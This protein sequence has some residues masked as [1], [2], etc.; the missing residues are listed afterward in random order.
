LIALVL[1]S[2]PAWA[3]P[4]S[5]LRGYGAQ[6]PSIVGQ[7]VDARTGAPLEKVLVLVEDTGNSALTDAD[8][9]FRIDGLSAGPHRLYVSVVGYALYRREV[10]AGPDA[11][12]VTVRLSEGTTAY[13]ETLTV[14]PEVFRAPADPVPSSQVLGSAELL[15]LRGVLADDPLRAVQVLPGVATGDDLRSE[16]TVRGSDFRHLTFTVDGFATPYL[17][18]SVRGVEDRGPTGSVAMINSDV[19]ED[20]TLLNGS[21]PQRYAG[22]TGAEV[23]FR[24]RDGSRDRRIFHAAVSGTNAAG[25]AEGPIGKHQ[26]GSW[27]ISARQSYL[28]LILHRLTY[29]TISFGFA[30]AQAKLTYDLSPRQRLDLTVLAG[31][32]RF[33][34]DPTLR[35]IDDV[36][37]GLNASVVGV[38]G[39]R[40]TLPRL[41]V[42]QRVLAADNH[43]R[44]QNPSKL[45]LDNGRDR[46]LAYRADAI[47]TARPSLEL[48]AGAEAERRDDSR[49]RRRIAPNRLNLVQLDDYTGDGLLTGTYA[50][51]RWTP[52]SRLTIAPGVRADRWSLTGQSTTSPWFQAEWRAISA[53]KVRAGAGVYRQ[54]PDFDKLLGVSGGIGLQPERADQYDLGVEQRIGRSLRVSMTLYD[55]EEHD[56]LRRPGAET[57]IVSGRVVR[58]SASTRYEN[59]LEGFARG[60]ELTVQRSI[61]GRG[62]SGWFSYAFGRNRYHDNVSGETYWG[63]ADQRHTM[64]AYALYR[65]SERASFVAKLRIGSNFPIPG[66]YASRDGM[67][68]V[69]D[70]RNTARLP[71]YSRL[72]LRANRTFNWSRRRLT[73]FAEIIN[74]LNRDNMRFIPPGVNVTTRTTSRPFD[75]MLPIVPSVGIL[76]EF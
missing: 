6:G 68:F 36:H 22:H 75:S 17:L 65:Y 53:L 58:G 15:N 5:P 40:V 8:G 13:S 35:E 4:P 30:D 37:V 25:V 69:T 14:T 19:L 48:A 18:H 29:R 76:I 33:E 49:V 46:Q 1:G 39:W 47:V 20:V 32:S 59:R 9:R 16:F 51:G 67:Y 27:L 24:L 72:D 34:N 52:F 26:R 42:S 10:A 11:P 3:Q 61:T 70:V 41:L 73:L 60:V 62:V 56:M 38:A 45:E 54:F 55:R 66:Y 7:V 43:F 21:Y 50:S 64:N 71:V 28:D 63:D 74:V 23:D 12:P 57:R 31:H 2:I 44:N